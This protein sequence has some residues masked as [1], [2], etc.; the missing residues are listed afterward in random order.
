MKSIIKYLV[1]FVRYLNIHAGAAAIIYIISI[2]VSFVFSF[3]ISTRV[4][5]NASQN[6]W[7]PIWT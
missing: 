5:T 4:D 3:L 2:C 6:F 7:W 1:H